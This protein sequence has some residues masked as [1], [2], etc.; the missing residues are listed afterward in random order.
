[1]N[2][3]ETIV[4]LLGICE[5]YHQQYSY[6]SEVVRKVADG[7]PYDEIPTWQ[8]DGAHSFIVG[9]T[10]SVFEQ[11]AGPY[12]SENWGSRHIDTKPVADLLNGDVLLATATGVLMDTESD[13]LHRVKNGEIG[14]VGM[15][16]CQVAHLLFDPRALLEEVSI[17]LERFN[18]H[19]SLS[20]FLADEDNKNEGGI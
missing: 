16:A 7:A 2:K 3:F 9:V 5:A 13:S 12:L 17:L 20:S 15:A 14:P 1:M 4:R 11:F 10:D 19:L 18:A 6:V 8:V